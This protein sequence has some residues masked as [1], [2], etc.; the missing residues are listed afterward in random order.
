MAVTI[1]AQK[2]DEITLKIDNGDLKKMEEVLTKWNFKDIQSFWRF[3]IS[4][5]LQTEEKK[6]WIQENG[7]PILIAPADHSIKD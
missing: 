7:N 4:I 2:D 3:S 6:L 5:L 1:I